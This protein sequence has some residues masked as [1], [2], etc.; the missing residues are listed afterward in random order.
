MD[1]QDL[2]TAYLARHR[3][4][5]DDSAIEHLH[6]FVAFLETALAALD[7]TPAEEPSAMPA[8]VAAVTEEPAAPEAPATEPAPEA[9]PE[10]PAAE[11]AP[12]AQAQ[13]PAAA[14]APAEATPPADPPAA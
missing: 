7:P 10:A 14:E 8:A 4:S 6:G 12:E 13:E 1:L 2:K 3:M 5:L 11:T 9:Q